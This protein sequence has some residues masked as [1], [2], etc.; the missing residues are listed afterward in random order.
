VLLNTHVMTMVNVM[1]ASV[2]KVMPLMPPPLEETAQDGTRN[3]GRC[4]RAHK[5]APARFLEERSS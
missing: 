4:Q 3:S 5:T 1:A 2:N